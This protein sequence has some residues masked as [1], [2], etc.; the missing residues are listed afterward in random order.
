MPMYI[1]QPGD[2]L[3][4][5]AKAFYD[6][7]NLWP[8]IHQANLALIPNENQVDVGMELFIPD[9]ADQ[10]LPPPPPGLPP[11][12]AQQVFTADEI[13]TVLPQAGNNVDIYWPS[14]VAG[15]TEAGCCD[16]P[17]QIAT[18]AT[19]RV[20][21]SAFA[22]IHEFGGNDYF[23]RMYEGRAGLGNTQPGDGARFH[24]RGF[25]QLTGRSNYQIYGDALG[26]DLT[27]DPDLAL[28]PDI[29]ARIFVKYFVDR[30]IPAMA[31]A[32]NWEGVRRAVN[33]GVNG[34]DDYIA[35]VNALTDIAQSRGLLLAA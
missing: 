23:T 35:A 29:S 15:L 4:K 24:G 27:G 3:S 8:R 18:V 20:E 11:E 1:V 22:P 28:N 26:V 34:W 19:I 6:D 9:A 10:P 12:L 17:T 32:R 2:T 13:R 5:I 30:R 25:I 31:A 14:L 33:G 16:A 21:T 7:E